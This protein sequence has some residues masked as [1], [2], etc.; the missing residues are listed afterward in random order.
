M[1][2]IG[3]ASRYGDPKPEEQ[4]PDAFL[5]LKE[6]FSGI[7]AANFGYDEVTGKKAIEKEGADMV[8]FARY[9]V[10]NPDLAERLIQGW[11]LNKDIDY[12]TLFTGGEKG[13]VDYPY[14]VENKKRPA[15]E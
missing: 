11:K 4:I 10:S 7:V 9:Y 13:Y 1:R 5:A 3:E 6:H 2:C 14:A 8:S 12:R 15:N